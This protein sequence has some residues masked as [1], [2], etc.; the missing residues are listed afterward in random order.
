[1][2]LASAELMKVH[3]KERIDQKEL[4]CVGKKLLLKYSNMKQVYRVYFTKLRI[5]L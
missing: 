3:T 2:M 5:K 1:M 4:R